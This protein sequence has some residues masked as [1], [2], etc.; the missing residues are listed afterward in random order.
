[1]MLAVIGVDLAIDGDH[2]AECRLLT[3]EDSN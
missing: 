1:M 2:E 3:Q